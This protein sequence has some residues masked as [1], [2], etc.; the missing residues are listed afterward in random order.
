MATSGLYT[1]TLTRDLVIANA[2]QE[3]GQLGVGDVASADDT[4]ICTQQLNIMLKHWAVKGLPLWAVSTI[5]FP[6]IASQVVYTLG[7][8]GNVPLAYRPLRVTEAWTRDVSGNDIQLLPLARQDYDMLGQKSQNVQTPVNYMF[9]PTIGSGVSQSNS[10]LSLY[11][12]AFD[13]TITI[14]LN[15]QRPLQDIVNSAD[16][17]DVPSEWFTAI[18]LGLA[19]GVA[20]KYRVD[21][22]DAMLLKA[23]AKEALQECLDF[24]QEE[25]SVYFQPDMSMGG[26]YGQPC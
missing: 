10:T 20:R 12:P 6:T 4:A 21:T 5:S 17:F 2:L 16:E 13:N 19:A 11:P 25:A 23:E 8:T 22:Q 7:P 1:F 9:M 14:F 15:V 18:V 3:I 26:N 24:N